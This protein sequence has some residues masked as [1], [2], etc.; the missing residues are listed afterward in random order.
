MAE[1]IDSSMIFKHFL[2][3]GSSYLIKILQTVCTS[4]LNNEQVLKNSLRLCQFYFSNQIQ[5]ISS[6]GRVAVLICQLAAE[7]LEYWE[8]ILDFLNTSLFDEPDKYVSSACYLIGCFVKMIEGEYLNLT[9]VQAISPRI[10]IYLNKLMAFVNKI[11]KSN[12]L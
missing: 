6:R 1:Q 7:C 8:F 3:R 11:V 5:R 12:L 9:H 10:D 2:Q 4:S